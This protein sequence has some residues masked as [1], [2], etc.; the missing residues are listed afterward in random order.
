MSV[1]MSNAVT[2]P[3]SGWVHVVEEVRNGASGSVKGLMVEILDSPP[4]KDGGEHV[5]RHP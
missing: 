5:R 4:A 2:A 3:A 1:D